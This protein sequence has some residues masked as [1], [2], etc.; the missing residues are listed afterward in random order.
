MTDIELALLKA[1]A[2]RPILTVSP[3]LQPIMAALHDAGYIAFYPSG[4]MAT[5]KGCVTLEEMRPKPRP[6]AQGKAA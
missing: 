1:L 6:G 5:E 3:T 2:N 4:W